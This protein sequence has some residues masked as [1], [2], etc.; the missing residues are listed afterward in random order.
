MAGRCHAV[1]G[2]RDARGTP[3]SNPTRL[4]NG[5]AE[6]LFPAP[7]HFRPNQPCPCCL[8]HTGVYGFV[9]K[10]LQMQMIL[11]NYKSLFEL[12][13]LKETLKEHLAQL[14]F[15]YLEALLSLL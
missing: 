10:P 12:A 14:F 3:K 15:K 8:T 2:R 1:H 6:K 5:S 7:D 9:F 11:L 4:L 13:S